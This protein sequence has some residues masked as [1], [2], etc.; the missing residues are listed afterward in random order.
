MMIAPTGS[1]TSRRCSIAS[2][3][4]VTGMSSSRVTRCT[5][6]SAEC[7]SRTTPSAWLWIGPRLASPDIASVTPRN[8]TTRP[9][10]EGAGLGLAVSYGI[11]RDHG[12][13]IDVESTPG[14]GSLFR[15][16]LPLRT[17]DQPEQGAPGAT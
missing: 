8:V 2:S 9:V 10:G 16:R 1:L 17:K 13:G 5:T 11:A 4:S 6:V 12:G 7:N 14:H 3:V 15:V